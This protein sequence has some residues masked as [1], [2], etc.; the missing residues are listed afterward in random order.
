MTKL[1]F[2]FR[3]FTKA[4]SKNHAESPQDLEQIFSPIH[5]ILPSFCVLCTLEELTMLGR[6][7]PT[8]GFRNYRLHNPIFDTITARTTTTGKKRWFSNA[9]SLPSQCVAVVT[10]DKQEFSVSSQ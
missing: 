3:S 10:M 8:F 2:D 7:L 5:K 6:P 1:I 4:A 9:R